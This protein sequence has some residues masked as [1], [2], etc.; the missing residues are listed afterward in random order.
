MGVAVE[1]GVEEGTEVGVA[2]GIAVFVGNGVC[3]GV[4]DTALGVAVA[5]G[6]GEV[7]RDHIEKSFARQGPVY[8]PSGAKPMLALC[9]PAGMGR[10]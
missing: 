2:V 5:G 7:L 4:L 6:V 1:V 9:V 8:Q 10:K 3:V